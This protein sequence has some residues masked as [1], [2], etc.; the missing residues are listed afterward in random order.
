MADS[1]N[2]FEAYNSIKKRQRSSI[3]KDIKEELGHDSDNDND[4][5]YC[6]EA[7]KIKVEDTGDGSPDNEGEQKSTSVQ[8]GARAGKLL[9][10]FEVQLVVVC[11]IF[12]DLFT[13]ITSMLLTNRIESSGND[14]E[15]YMFA[16]LRVLE[17]L[18]SFVLFFFL[19]ELC[20]L[21]VV[22]R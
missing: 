6:R 1:M 3:K 12:L 11:C 4:G 14:I 7:P 22:F 2:S 9:E 21:V 17:S 10:L 15:D 18:S 8:T 19:L 13:S 20:T 16:I 5:E